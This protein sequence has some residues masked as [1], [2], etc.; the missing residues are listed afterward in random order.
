[1]KMTKLEALALVVLFFAVSVPAAAQRG[2]LFARPDLP[3]FI[4]ESLL[5]GFDWLIP[6]KVDLS[7]LP[8]SNS[9]AAALRSLVA[10]R[11]KETKNGEA[12]SQYGLTSATDLIGRPVVSNRLED[13]V[14]SSEVAFT[15]QVSRKVA[16]LGAGAWMPKTRLYL[17]IEEVL[18]DPSGQLAPGQEWSYVIL[19]GRVR[20][21]KALICHEPPPDKYIPEEDGH[22][23]FIGNFDPVNSG[24]NLYYRVV[25]E[26]KEGEILPRPNLFLTDLSPVPVSALREALKSKAKDTSR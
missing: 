22:V 8:I 21:G 25:F 3:S 10:E 7:G 24:E 13:V 20:L 9:A 16:G 5:A 18:H 12:C 14:R 1:M 23:L 19:Y 15:G 26:L 6:E 17:K 4:P 2:L 11:S